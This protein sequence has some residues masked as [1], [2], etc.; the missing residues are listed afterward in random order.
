MLSW[1]ADIHYLWGEE[2]KARD[3]SSQLLLLYQSL[4]DKTGEAL[5]LS[6]ISSSYHLENDLQKELEYSLKDFGHLA[7]Y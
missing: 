7:V 1:I 5:T 4:G 6:R 2:E 3:I